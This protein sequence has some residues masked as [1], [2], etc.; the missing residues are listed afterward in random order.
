MTDRRKRSPEG[1]LQA[2]A[3]RLLRGASMT[4]ELLGEQ[5]GCDRET[6]RKAIAYLA[7]R[8]KTCKHRLPGRRVVLYSALG[9]REPHDRRGKPAAC[10][11]HRGAAAYAKWLLIMTKRHGA[12]WRPPARGTALEQC[13][14]QRGA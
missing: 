2:R 14:S 9:N 5:L 12:Q 4:A 3:W 8:N 6:A 7:R 10:R 1:T 13:W 11:N